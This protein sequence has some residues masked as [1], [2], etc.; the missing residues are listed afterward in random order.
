MLTSL[1]STGEVCLQNRTSKEKHVLMEP[2][3]SDKPAHV[4]RAGVHE[5]RWGVTRTAGLGTLGEVIQWCW[6]GPCGRPRSGLFG[7]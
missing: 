5:D 4:R 2:Y 6:K 3:Q 1:D 7:I